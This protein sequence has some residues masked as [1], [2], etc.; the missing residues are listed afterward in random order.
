[1]R[2]LQRVL[3]RHTLLAFAANGSVLKPQFCIFFPPRFGSKPP[4]DG[5]NTRAS[6]Q[7]NYVDG[8]NKKERSFERSQL[9]E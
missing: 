8:G 2:R 3:Q 6:R 5:S 9:A 7:K 4:P 1:L